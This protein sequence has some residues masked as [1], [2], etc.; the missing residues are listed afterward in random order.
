MSDIQAIL[1]VIL[2]LAG[3][4]F[5]FVGSLGVIRLPD[6]YSRT[7][8]VSKSDTLGIFLVISG[9]IVYEGPT[10][11]SIKL[12]F[13]ILFILL[14]NP[15][16]THALARAAFKQGVKPILNGRDNNKEGGTS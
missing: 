4:F 9:L 6:F 10:L 3:I 7:H 15:V 5:M 13:I 8:A 11:N 12:T 16:G 1:S 14:S 2:I